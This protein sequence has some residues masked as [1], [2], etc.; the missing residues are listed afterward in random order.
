MCTQRLRK[1]RHKR[2]HPRIKRVYQKPP[3]PTFTTDEMIECQG[4]HESFP[5]VCDD[6]E[7]GIKIHCAGCNQFYHCQVAGTCYGKNCSHEVSLGSIHHL[8]WC[9]HCVPKCAM[10]QEKQNRT[11]RCVCY[12]CL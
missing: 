9:I 5:L 4:C 10:N 8:S 1:K 11:E 3:A 2:V 6:S 7:Q 12:K